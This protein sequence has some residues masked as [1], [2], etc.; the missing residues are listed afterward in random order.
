MTVTL[1]LL[2]I[3]VLLVVGVP[4][5]VTL[6]LGTFA[7][8]YTTD[9]L[10]LSLIGEGLF[11]GV[12]SFA[13][14]AIPLFILT[15][16]IMVRSGLAYQLLDFAEASFGSLRSG[17]GT[18][19]VM[20]CGLFACISG[21]DAADAAAVGRITMDRLVERGYPKAY[22]CALVASGACTGIL[23]PPS[24]AYIILGMVLGVSATTLF[25]A[26][27]VPGV[28]VL[29]AVIVTNAIIN[30]IKGYEKSTVKF[31]MSRWLTALNAAKWA[32]SIPI[33][34]LGGIYS[35]WFTPTESAAVAAAVAVAIGLLQNRIT[36]AQFPTMLGTSARVCGVILPIIAVALLFAQALTVNDV[37]QRFVELVMA[38]G[39]DRNTV[40]FMMLVILVIAGCFMETSPCIVILAP[41]MWPL[42]QKV[43][44]EQV[45]FCVFMITT[46]GLGFITPPFGL[47]LFVMSGLTR[48][49]LTAI[50]RQALPF[51]GAMILVAAAIGYIPQISMFTFN[52]S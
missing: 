41:L 19:T 49:P 36:V 11:E 17:F 3:V 4:F 42:A 48:T 22:A 52:K 10:P 8:L 31:S 6:G 5:W 51:V 12:D 47:N 14:I 15:G 50:A 34:I 40:I 32:L 39:G 24:I 2:F 45:H 27:F 23:I 43:G 44:M 30:R 33:I 46:L 9:A 7:L 18:S 25:Q 20:G 13:L 37:P 21:S 16:D 35:G 26:A 1:C 38:F 29:L 28:M